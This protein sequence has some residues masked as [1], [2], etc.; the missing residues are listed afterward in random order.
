M[1]Q[2][3]D[4]RTRRALRR[5]APTLAM[6]LVSLQAM[7][8]PKMSIIRVEGDFGVDITRQPFEDALRQA[9]IS[10]VDIVVFVWDSQ[11]GRSD[12]G[13]TVGD[14][15]ADAPE[16]VRVVS[17][18]DR[19]FGATVF[20]LAASDELLVLEG[21]SG[22]TVISFGIDE[23]VP[24]EETDEQR[25]ERL[26][27]IE[28]LRA[29]SLEQV[30]AHATE[31]GQASDVYRA[32]MDPSATFAA[33][34]DGARVPLDGSTEETL[35]LNPATA[36]DSGLARPAGSERPEDIAEA[37]GLE[38]F[39]LVRTPAT[40]YTIRQRTVAALMRNVTVVERKLIKTFDDVLDDWSR[41]EAAV[42]YTRAADPHQ[43]EYMSTPAGDDRLLTGQAQR[44][45]TANVREYGSRLTKLKHLM[46]S[47][48]RGK[49]RMNALVLERNAAIELVS[50]SIGCQHRT[51]G[52]TIEL[53]ETDIEDLDSIWDWCLN[54]IEWCKRN[55][56]RR[57]E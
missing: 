55:Q 14:T 2:N 18:I 41:L 38:S 45:W 32:I 30:V 37:L 52:I 5:L 6:L 46:E 9:G 54:Q 43:F 34:V 53:T 16:G 4:S 25:T 10:G 27:A 7:A 35:E 47:A 21:S 28:E 11:G 12:V 8:Q 56:H 57:F 19:A 48:A 29:R 44:Q 40:K 31:R 42:E 33:D 50:A 1:N 51:K 20:G 26:K 15:L 24:E 13:M 49:D 36:S 22:K 17:V 3:Q 39:E 23:E